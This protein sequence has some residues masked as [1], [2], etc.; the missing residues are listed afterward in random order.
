[1]TSVQFL[2]SGRSI[3]KPYLRKSREHI[4]YPIKYFII[5]LINK[6]NQHHHVYLISHSKPIN[7]FIHDSRQKGNDIQ[8]DEVIV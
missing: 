1:M 7:L 5:T 8:A 4:T 2:V 6:Y 3:Q